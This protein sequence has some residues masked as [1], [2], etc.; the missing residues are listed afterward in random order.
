MLTRLVVI[1]GGRLPPHISG[2]IR[3]S[4]KSRTFDWLF[5]KSWPKEEVPPGLSFFDRL[6]WRGN[7]NPEHIRHTNMVSDI[8]DDELMEVQGKV[9][10]A[11][12]PARDGL[13]RALRSR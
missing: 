8:V 7:R 5:D 3:K 12:R 1:R 13:R 11:T 9:W 4:L 6:L 2:P 10:T